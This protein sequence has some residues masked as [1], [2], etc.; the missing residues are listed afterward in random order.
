LGNQRKTGC[1]EQKDQYQAR[2]ELHID[3]AVLSNTK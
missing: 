1:Q 2:P 3:Q